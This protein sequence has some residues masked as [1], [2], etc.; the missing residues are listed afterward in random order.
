MARDE[1]RVTNLEADNSASIE[2][3][4]VEP[5]TVNTTNGVCVVD[6]FDNKNNSLQIT[7]AN[8]ASA[9]AKVTLQ[10]GDKYPNACL[11]KLEVTVPGNSIHVFTYTDLSRF[12]TNNGD[13]CID[14][15]SGFAG[16]IYATARRAGL[17][18]VA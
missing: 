3:A 6:A 11:G 9:S 12:E 15:E 7:I 14:F 10:A 13:V 16:T 18:P 4:L 5:A 8:T 1:I 2:I 17:K